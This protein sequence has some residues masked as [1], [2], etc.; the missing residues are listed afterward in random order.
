MAE[1]KYVVDF[2][3]RAIYSKEDLV[4]F[5]VYCTKLDKDDNYWISAIMIDKKHQGKGYGK[6]AMGMLIELMTI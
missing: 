6:A 2:E 5:I 3:L 1:S 4:G